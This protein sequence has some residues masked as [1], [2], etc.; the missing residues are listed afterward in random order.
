MIDPDAGLFRACR[1]VIALGREALLTQWASALDALIPDRRESHRFSRAHVHAVLACARAVC[2]LRRDVEPAGALMAFG[3][4][5]GAWA[6]TTPRPPIVSTSWPSAPVARLQHYLRAFHD[7][8]ADGVGHLW[9]L[10]MLFLT[11]Q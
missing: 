4:A 10:G 3:D 5:L 1:E 6:G 8:I 2:C 11:G 9:D 7:D